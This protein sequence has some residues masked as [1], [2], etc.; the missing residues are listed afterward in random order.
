MSRVGTARSSSPFSAFSRAFR[1]AFFGA[2]SLPGRAALRLIERHARFYRR[3][4]LV[5]ASG[6]AEPLFYLFSVG[7]GVGGLV[8]GVTG[9]G[10]QLVPYREFVAPG[11]LAVSALNGALADSTF[12]VYGRLKFEK[13][14]D[15]VL[16]T[17]IGAGDVAL[18]EIGWAVL[19]G[20]LY[21][22]PFLIVMAGMGLIAS[23]WALLALPAAALISFA[24]A[25]VGVACTT[26]MRSWQDFEYV[27]LVSVPLFLFSGTFYPLSVYPHVIAV[28]VEWT[29]L[30]QGVV[31]LRDLVLGFPSPDLAWRAAYLLLL[32]VG[33]LA[34]AGRRIATLLLV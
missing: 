23:P 15:A 29:P 30:Y 4:W 7:V 9:P 16:A 11:L 28:I 10:G 6:A 1:T 34:V 32:G 13:L 22:V 20:I 31:I 2:S 24:V 26:Y 3:L 5:V 14:Y 19:R 21:C 18:G 27:T 25:S 17:P 12:N 8:G 33:G